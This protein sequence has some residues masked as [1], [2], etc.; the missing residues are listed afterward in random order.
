VLYRRYK[1]VMGKAVYFKGPPT[2]KHLRRS[3]QKIA[4]VLT[5]FYKPTV[6]TIDHPKVFASP[7]LLVQL[8]FYVCQFSFF[9][10]LVT[11]LSNAPIDF[12]ARY[13]SG[14]VCERKCLLGSNRSKLFCWWN[15]LPSSFQR[16]F[17]TQIEKVEY[18]L[19]G[20]R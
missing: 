4:T 10:L 15:Y 5:S 3:I 17:C 16:A 18:I 13:S 20:K 2:E 9:L 12:D 6:I 1:Q 14:T 8:Q 19:N 11:I 7:I